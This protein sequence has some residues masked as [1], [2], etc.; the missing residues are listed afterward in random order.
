[1]LQPS[2]YLVITTACQPVASLFNMTNIPPKLLLFTLRACVSCSTFRSPSIF[3]LSFFLSFS[4]SFFLSFF[5]SSFL[6]S[7][8]PS[9]FLSF[10]SFLFFK[11]SQR[12]GLG[13]TTRPASVPRYT[14]FMTPS[15]L[16]PSQFCHH[17]S[18]TIPPSI[19]TSILLP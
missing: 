7:F 1:M 19:P 17:L 15:S 12:S 5:L 8:L 6:P 4:L 3:F 2:A 10:F 9:F 11:A 16:F 18:L 14:E 13:N